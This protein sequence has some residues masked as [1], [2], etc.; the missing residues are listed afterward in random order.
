MLPPIGASREAVANLQARW[1]ALRRTPPPAKTIVSI[2]LLSRIIRQRRAITRTASELV[3]C[4]TT[5]LGQTD[6]STVVRAL[7]NLSP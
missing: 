4:D 6:Q 3:V 5:D 7:S 2:N 1:L